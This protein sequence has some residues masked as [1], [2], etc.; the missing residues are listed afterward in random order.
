M[1][2]V[3]QLQ[4]VVLNL[5]TNAEQ[6][7]EG[8]GN[9]RHRLT[10][11]TRTLADMVRIEVEDTGHGVPEE[12]MHQIFNPFYTT[13]PTGKGTGLGLSISLGIVGEHGGR[14]WAENITGG[15]RFTVELPRVEGNDRMELTL[16]PSAPIQT[17][18]SLRIL[19]A[20]DEDALRSALGRFLSSEGH[21]VVTVGSGSEAIWRAE[22]DEE[23]DVILLDL[24][25]PDVS[26]QQVFE[27]WC[28][29][30]HELSERVVFITGDI[31][32]PDLQAFLRATGRPYIA[33]PFE[34]SAIVNVLPGSRLA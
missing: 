29:D 34:F 12:V 3:H 23:F 32:S 22:G 2:D 5:I 15:A 16:V 26:G 27:R 21:S 30:H 1:V 28:K 14:I 20:D 33:K 25:M 24:R 6:A 18:E 4:Q 7:M 13:K 8:F 11:R 31:V 19:V 10:L 9:E 17:P